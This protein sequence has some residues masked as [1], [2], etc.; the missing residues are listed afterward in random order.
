MQNTFCISFSFF[1]KTAVAG[2]IDLRTYA[3]CFTSQDGRIYLSLPDLRVEKTWMLKELQK[4][5]EKLGGIVF[6]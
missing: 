5:A 1:L 4:A 6:C 3:S 2:S